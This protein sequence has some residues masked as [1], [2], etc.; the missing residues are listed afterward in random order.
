MENRGFF[1]RTITFC[2][3]SYKYGGNGGM[4][5][6]EMAGRKKTPHGLPYEVLSVRSYFLLYSTV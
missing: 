3:F 6:N 2:Y 4:M 5:E 1:L